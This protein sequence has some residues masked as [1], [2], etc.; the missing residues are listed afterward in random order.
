MESFIEVECTLKSLKKKQLQTEPDFNQVQFG[1]IRY[2]HLKTTISE[3]KWC[4]LQRGC[5]AC[6]IVALIALYW[7]VSGRA[8]AS[9]STRWST[10]DEGRGGANSCHLPFLWNAF[11]EREKIWEGRWG[12]NIYHLPLFSF[13]AN[14]FLEL[15]VKLGSERR[16]TN[17]YFIFFF[18]FDCTNI[19]QTRCQKNHKSANR[20]YLLLCRACKW[21]LSVPSSGSLKG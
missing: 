7:C 18:C 19:S 3:T 1:I 6:C 17:R 5:I 4:A 16:C 21:Q 14:D 13:F 11:L 9:V 12:T 10:E 15:N 20:F 8:T 2:M